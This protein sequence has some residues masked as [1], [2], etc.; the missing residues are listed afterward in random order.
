MN[1]NPSNG[2][3]VHQTDICPRR[4]CICRAPDAVAGIDRNAARIRF[5]RSDIDRVR[6]VR[7][8]RQGS[9]RWRLVEDIRPGCSEV[10]GFPHTSCSGT[11]VDQIRVGG[12][13]RER[14]DSPADVGGP[15]AL[16][17]GGSH[18]A[19]MGCT[20]FLNRSPRLLIKLRV[21][22]VV[23]IHALEHEPIVIN[24]LF[25][26]TLFTVREGE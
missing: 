5:A 7:V 11:G 17:H 23:R 14:R 24:G 12:M 10:R 21:D 16:P 4:P 22:V 19:A 6:V 15:N 18:N 20:H 8:K 13:E 25:R 3:D 1:R 9:N 2:S 26:K